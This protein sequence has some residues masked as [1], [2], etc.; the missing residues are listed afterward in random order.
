MSE[1]SIIRSYWDKDEHDYMLMNG[2]WFILMWGF[3]PSNV[4]FNDYVLCLP[5]DWV[6]WPI[7]RWRLVTSTTSE[8]NNP[9]VP[10]PAVAKY[11]ATGHPI[12]P[13]PIIAILVLII[14]DWP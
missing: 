2:C 13:L 5:T 12:P 8:S 1:P 9:K 3:K 10:T 6:W 14:F 4:Y 7:C 11:I